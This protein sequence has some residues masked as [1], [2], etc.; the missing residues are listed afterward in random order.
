MLKTKEK[1]KR[2]QEIL[3]DKHNSIFLTL[4]ILEILEVLVFLVSREIPVEGSSSFI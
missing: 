3:V 1:H 2:Q 4:L